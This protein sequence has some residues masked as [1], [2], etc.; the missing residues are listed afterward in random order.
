MTNKQKLFQDM[1][2]GTLLYTVVLGFFNDYTDIISISTYSILFSAAVV[3]QILTYLTLLL[4]NVVIK[5]YKQKE[6]YR[7]GLVLFSVWL[8]LFFSK[9]VFLEVINIIFGTTVEISGFIGLLLM[10]ICLTL[11]QKL[12]EIVY[13]KLGN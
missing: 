2:L 5:K 4:K 7:K 11:A 6:N 8:I 9:F 10:I 12:V 1:V 3:L 13:L